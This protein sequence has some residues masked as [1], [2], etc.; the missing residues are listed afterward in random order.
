MSNTYVPCVAVFRSTHTDALTTTLS[1]GGDSRPFVDGH[2]TAS[3]CALQERQTVL[4]PRHF[5]ATVVEDL[6]EVH[7]LPIS[8]LGGGNFDPG[9]ST[10]VTLLPHSLDSV[11][12]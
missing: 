7:R 2:E 6:L 12:W 1:I 4:P 10:P 11:G 3:T 5:Q 8:C 9:D